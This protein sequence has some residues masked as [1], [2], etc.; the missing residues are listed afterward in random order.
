MIAGI[1]ISQEIF[2]IDVLTALKSSLEQRRKHVLRLL[3]LY[4]DQALKIKNRPMGIRKASSCKYESLLSWI[5]IY[6]TIP[7]VRELLIL[8]RLHLN[9]LRTYDR[10]WAF[11]RIITVIMSYLAWWYCHCDKSFGYDYYFQCSLKIA[12]VEIPK[13]Y[14][15]NSLYWKRG[16]RVLEM[17]R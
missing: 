8:S 4:G 1:H 9:D 10:E 13:R 17:R 12:R 15:S 14:P 3:K 2:A 7:V 16:Q 6:F 11:F 5:I